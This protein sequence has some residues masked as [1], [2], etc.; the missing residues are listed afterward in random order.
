MKR[1]LLLASVLLASCANQPIPTSEA[2]FD[3][4][5]GCWQ[6][7]RPD[8][9]IYEEM[10]LPAR[11]DGTVGVGREIRD[12]HM[13]SSEYQ[14]IDFRPD[15]TIAFIAQ[16]VGQDATTFTMVEHAPGKLGFANAQHDFP[17][18]I[19]YRYVDLSNIEARIS[20][21]DGARAIA[22]PMHRIDCQG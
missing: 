9:S 16:P 11:K 12:G 6:L 4:L 14:R 13:V 15:G 1:T 17:Q 22:Y 21:A 18:R 2:S 3:W 10:W 5:A 20:G 8:G 19:E 7:Q